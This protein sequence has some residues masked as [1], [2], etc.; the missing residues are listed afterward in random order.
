MRQ[1]GKKCS[2]RSSV[3]GF[4]VI[5][6]SHVCAFCKYRLNYY[7]NINNIPIWSVYTETV[8]CKLD[9]IKENLEEILE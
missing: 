7:D 2:E 1:G 6:G 4:D 9:I 3:V 5:I 8:E